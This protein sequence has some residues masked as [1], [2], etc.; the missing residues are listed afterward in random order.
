MDRFLV[1]TALKETFVNDNFSYILLGEW[2]KLYSDE[3]I[4]SK[5]NYSVAS[6]HWDDRIKLKDDHKYLKTVYEKVLLQLGLKLNEIHN[7]NKSERY[8]R[9]I[10]GPWLGT[11]L[12]I[13]FD[14]WETLKFIFDGEKKFSMVRL[15][16]NFDLM[17]TKDFDDCIAKVQSDTWNYGMYLRIIELNFKSNVT[18]LDVQSQVCLDEVKY[19]PRINYKN[20]LIKILDRF[21]SLIRIEQKILL[22]HSYF[23]P[24]RLLSL[25]L[26]LGQ[27]PRVYSSEFE[28]DFSVS[29]DPHVRS[30]TLNLDGVESNF[31]IFIINNI[32][33][34]IPKAYLEGF[35]Q[36]KAKA[37]K[38]RLNPEIILTAN[39]YWGDE[40]F[41]IWTAEMV[42]KDKKFI[43]SHHGGAFPSLFC[44]FNHE[45][46]SSDVYITW[47]KPFHPKQKQLPPNKVVLKKPNSTGD[48]CSIIGYESV[49]FSFR[50]EA[51]PVSHQSILCFDQ[52]ITF[53]DK[54]DSKIRER[55]KV[56]PY[57]DLG[58]NTKK[59]YED[60]LG[61][62][63][64]DLK[65]SYDSFI[66]SSKIIVSTYPQTTFSESLAS[67]KPTI[68]LY[69]DELFELIPET[70]KLMKKLSEAKIVFTDPVLAARHI[71][72]VWDN[73]EEWWDSPKVVSAKEIFY[74][75]AL[76]IDR[77]WK[78]EW[79]K[80]LK[81]I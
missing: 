4:W 61:I 62:N 40:L 28:L 5:L 25:N 27:V 16:Y 52:V 48:T 66:N 53:C 15:T 19:S 1:T 21:F 7:V 30:E 24:N 31:E 50:A 64:V 70:E 34:D 76:R 39:A 14:R 68:L 32:L 3:S 63:S 59:R 11:Y 65:S 45:E 69:K 43:I 44:N 72:N 35:E 37:E 2:C 47:F 58:W 79:V 77:E 71:N 12:P 36:I 54:L 78:K 56:R 57:P 75:V 42:A 38:I 33:K 73:V 74:E 80:I 10:L 67:G 13:I 29:L 8:W 51:V 26:A 23:P 9:I 20:Q 60:Q 41:K 6:Y 49:R 46:D 17:V 55:V 22:Y 81:T 18:F